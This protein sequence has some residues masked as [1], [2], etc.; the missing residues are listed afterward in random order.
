MVLQEIHEKVEKILKSI[1]NYWNVE[2]PL[3]KLDIVALPFLSVLKPIDNWGLVV[4]KFVLQG[5]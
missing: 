2:L 4:F 3:K 5:I 1:Q